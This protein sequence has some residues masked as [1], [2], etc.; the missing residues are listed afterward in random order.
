MRTSAFFMDCSFLSWS[1]DV[2]MMSLH[3]STFHKRFKGILGACSF[4]PVN[5]DD[6][7]PCFDRGLLV[8]K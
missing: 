7:L 3:N 6:P 2:K 8:P 1:W 5:C 4:L